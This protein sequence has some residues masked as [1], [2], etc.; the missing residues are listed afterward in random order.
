MAACETT[1]TR[2]P[3]SPRKAR[4][5][6]VQRWQQLLDDAEFIVQLVA[7]APVEAFGEEGVTLADTLAQVCDKLVMRRPLLP[8]SR[9]RPAGRR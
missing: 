5:L 6:I 9:L 1:T 8:P 2:P 7:D 3:L 4:K